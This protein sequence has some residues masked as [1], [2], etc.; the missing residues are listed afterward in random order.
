MNEEEDVAP[1]ET[2]QISM[3]IP[4]FWKPN[5]EIWFAQLEA[6]FRRSKITTDQTKFDTVVSSVDS[7]LLSQISDLILDPPR[8]NKYTALKNKLIG[9]FSESNTK[10]LQTLLSDLELGDQK[11]SQLLTKIKTLSQNKLDDELLKT[12]W[13]RHLPINIQTILSISNDD[14]TKLSELADK[15][16]DV[17]SNYS[18]QSDRNLS[19]SINSSELDVLRK[20]VTELSIEIESLRKSSTKTVYHKNERQQRK[21]IQTQPQTN[22]SNQNL[23]YYHFT[24]G[25]RARKCTPPCLLA[26]TVLNQENTFPMFFRRQ[27]QQGQN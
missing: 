25:G 23:C 22:S 13:L 2:A 16:T 4:Q 20:Q 26:K 1:L 18:S 5:P 27:D 19:K 24:F 17:T 6:Q 11:P 7:D 15:I 9:L 14:L 3:K 8:E 10:K 12:L 21:F